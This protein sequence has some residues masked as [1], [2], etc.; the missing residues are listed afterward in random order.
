MNE[1]TVLMVSSSNNNSTFSSDFSTLLRCQSEFRL[2][3]LTSQ[4]PGVV[5]AYWNFF[6]ELFEWFTVLFK[7]NLTLHL[8][9]LTCYCCKLDVNRRSVF[10]QKKFPIFYCQKKAYQCRSGFCTTFSAVISCRSK[11]LSRR[12]VTALAFGDVNVGIVQRR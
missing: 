11:T 8:R 3:P 1:L 5:F 2:S 9:N 7:E 10:L 12:D 4:F 6:V